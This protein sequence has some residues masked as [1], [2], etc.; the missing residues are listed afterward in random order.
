[1]EPAIHSKFGSERSVGSIPITQ[2]VM[3]ALLLL[4]FA[5]NRATA[6]RPLSA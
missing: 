3:V 5:Y 4:G 2:F 1:M 6:G